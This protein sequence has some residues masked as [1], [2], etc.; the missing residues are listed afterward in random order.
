MDMFNRR[1]IF[2]KNIYPAY[3]NIVEDVNISEYKSLKSKFERLRELTREISHQINM[4]DQYTSYNGRYEEYTTATYNI[5][6]KIYNL[7][8]E[9]DDFIGDII[10]E[11]RESHYNN[12]E[13][14]EWYLKRMEYEIFEAIMGD[15]L[16][17]INYIEK[18]YVTT[19][20][21]LTELNDF[22]RGTR[23][24]LREVERMIDEVLRH[25]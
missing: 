5:L 24:A 4:L 15:A 20:E 8:E 16:H 14:F 7:S 17:L 2:D 3:R 25:I 21:F 11:A 19:L 13:S 12:I 9:A 18:G 23:R 22:V 1:N 6:T 10:I